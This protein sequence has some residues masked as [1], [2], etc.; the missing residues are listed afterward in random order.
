MYEVWFN[1]NFW[2][3]IEIS[4]RFRLERNWCIEIAGTRS[5]VRSYKEA[6]K[7]ALGGLCLNRY[8]EG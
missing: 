8:I 6:F 2:V 7:Q 5:Y 1:P 4:K 3:F